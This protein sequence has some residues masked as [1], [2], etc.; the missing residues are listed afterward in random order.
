M[1]DTLAAFLSDIRVRYDDAKPQANNGAKDNS[2]AALQAP[3]G[4]TPLR[5][6]PLPTGSIT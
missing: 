1:V 2:A 5:P 3:T 4:R 6:D